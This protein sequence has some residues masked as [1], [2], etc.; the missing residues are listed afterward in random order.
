MSASERLINFWGY[1]YF[2]INS[3]KY[4]WNLTQ[5]L[6]GKILRSR[7]VRNSVFDIRYSKN[8]KPQTPT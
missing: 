4:Y 6:R 1:P 8:F 5:N 7:V 2:N 3:F